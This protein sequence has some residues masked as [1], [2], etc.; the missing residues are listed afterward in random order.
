MA[1]WRWRKPIQR[2]SW[3]RGGLFLESGYSSKTGGNERLNI[4]INGNTMAKISFFSAARR[5]QWR[6]MAYL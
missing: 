1:A 5:R 6:L 3:R 4:S 2:I